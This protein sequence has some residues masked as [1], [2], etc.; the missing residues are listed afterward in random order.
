M[1]QGQFQIEQATILDNKIKVTWKDRHYSD[2]HL[3]WLRHQCECTQCGSSLDGLR[4]NW[5]L[6]IPDNP[7]VS[8]MSQENDGISITWADN[9]HQSHYP[10]SWLR[11]HCYSDNSHRSRRHRVT[12]WDSTMGDRIPV[13]DVPGITS[14]I[15]RH[16]ALL[17]TVRDVGFCKLTNVD[18]RLSGIEEA[19][20]LFGPVRQT[21]WGISEINEKNSQ[22]NVG[23][24]GRALLPHMDETYRLSS[25]GVT[26]LQMVQ[27][28]EKGG[29][30]ILVD[31]FEVARRVRESDPEAFRLLSTLAV[32]FK[33]HHK[34]E[35]ADGR[36][37]MLVSRSPIIKLD[38][39]GEIEGVR[40]NE[41]HISPLDIRGELVE[42][43]YRALKVLFTHTYDPALEI[44]LPLQS[45]EA[46]VFENNRVL[47]GRTEFVRGE[48]PRY[49]RTCTVDLEEFHST[50]RLLQMKLGRPGVNQVIY[51]G[52]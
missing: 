23:D 47:H 19:A 43:Y 45:G 24:S 13:F 46:M 2:F 15:D 41:R 7:R 32:T 33:R 4:N 10:A 8:S 31:G 34:G 52:M 3:V 26:I 17:E 5:I 20:N 48:K 18:T 35:S 12:L 27:P 49:A 36:P 38:G 16:L 11:N 30:S 22:Y 25:V 28:S 44:Q 14:D 9:E 39:E 50:M 40:I 29:H 37:R 51:Q 21:H 42:P 6:E 1:N